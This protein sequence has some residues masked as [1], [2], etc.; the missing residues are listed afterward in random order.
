MKIR[1]DIP[2]YRDDFFDVVAQ[3]AYPIPMA[4][5]AD[6]RHLGSKPTMQLMVRDVFICK[7]ETN[8][9]IYASKISPSEVSFWENVIPIGR[10][11]LLFAVP[12]EALLDAVVGVPAAEIKRTI[13]IGANFGKQF[14]H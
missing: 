10:E 14:D 1:I 4:M 2:G 12:P 3:V 9:K 5:P 13:D 11:K 8:S 7:A 6:P